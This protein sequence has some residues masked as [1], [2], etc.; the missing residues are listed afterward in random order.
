[1]STNKKKILEVITLASSAENFISDQPQYLREK[2]GY[3][4]HMICSPSPTLEKYAVSQG[5]SYKA[6]PIER[7]VSLKKDIIA[8]R[9][10]RRYMKEQHFDILIAHSYPNACLISMTAGMMSHIPY[11]IEVAHGALQ[12]GLSGLMKRMVILS[13]T[14]NSFWAKKVICVSQSVCK[15]R[16]LD[17]IDKP[18]K[19]VLLAKGTSNGVDALNKFNPEKISID[20]IRQ[21][22]EKYGLVGVDFV[23]G[24]CGRLVQDKGVVEL[25][26]G[27][28]MLLNRYPEKRIKLLIIGRPEQRDGLPLRTLNFIQDSKNIIFTGAVPYSEIQKYYMLMDV[29]VLP[30]YREGFPTVVLEASAMKRPV[31]TTKKTGCIDSIIDGKTGLFVEIDPNSIA[32]AVEKIFDIE[33]AHRLGENGRKWVL[34][35]YEHTIVK[36]AMLNFINELTKEK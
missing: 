15:R 6:I 26:D 1:M 7:Q 20:E 36:E 19:Q 31:L 27:F 12:E 10:I 4:V 28:K 11:R 24:F 14:W 18:N 2:G 34:D 35:N 29:F 21:L 13:E 3:E 23:L 32:D 16:V 9:A 33:I 8:Y 22:K 25:I 17:R 5:I 30:S